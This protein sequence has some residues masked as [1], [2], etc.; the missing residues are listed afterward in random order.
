MQGEISQKFPNWEIGDFIRPIQ[1]RNPY[2]GKKIGKQS[3]FPKISQCETSQT[4][5]K[6]KDFKKIDHHLLKILH[7]I[8]LNYENFLSYW[9]M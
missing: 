4:W 2:A 1:T 9:E 8:R 5:V 7:K 6:L 3:N